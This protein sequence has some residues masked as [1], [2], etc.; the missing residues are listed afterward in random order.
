MQRKLGRVALFF[1]V[2]LFIQIQFAMQSQTQ[3]PVATLQ[4]LMAAHATRAD[5]YGNLQ[6]RTTD[7]ALKS[8]FAGKAAASHRCNEELLKELA[9]FGDAAQSEAN[10]DNEHQRV[11]TEITAGTGNDSERLAEMAGQAESSLLALYGHALA[12]TSGL[13][14]SLRGLLERQEKSF[15]SSGE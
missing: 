5:G 12:D 10:R 15:S 9:Q 2:C 13:P 14:D 6:G 8:E 1:S 4:E 7:A 11:W 3:N